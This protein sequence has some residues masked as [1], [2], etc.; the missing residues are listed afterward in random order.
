LADISQGIGNLIGLLLF[1]LFSDRMAKASSK[2]YVTESGVLVMTPESRLPPMIPGGVLLPIGLF[3][4][5][6]T[7]EKHVHYIVPIFGTLL[8]GIANLATT[9]PVITY[10]VDAYPLYAAS[11]LAASTLIRAI[12]GAFI[13]IVAP[14]MYKALGL[15]WGNSLIAFVAATMI[16]VPFLFYR[17]GEYFRN[18]L[19][20]EDL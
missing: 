20:I 17:Y 9:M 2:S 7:A 1:G 8:F 5:G 18:K 13:P 15:G 10:L 11:A 3:I 19:R 12:L 4:Y 6:W 16:P 14:P